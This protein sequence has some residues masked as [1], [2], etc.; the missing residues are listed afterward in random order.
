MNSLCAQAADRQVGG[1]TR[2]D[3]PT[4]HQTVTVDQLFKIYFQMDTLLN[5]IWL[6]CPPTIYGCMLAVTSRYIL[7]EM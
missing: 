1:D 2:A 7:T 4:E 5:Y 6:S 3:I